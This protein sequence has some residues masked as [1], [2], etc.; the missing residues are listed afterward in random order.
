[1]NCDNKKHV[2]A[3]AAAAA[4]AAATTAAVTIVAIHCILLSCR[5]IIMY[6]SEL[7]LR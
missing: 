6:W 2:V 7:L 1:M 4:A 5:I 3:A